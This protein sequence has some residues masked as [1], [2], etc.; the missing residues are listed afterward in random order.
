MHE[1]EIEVK[2]KAYRLSD[3]AR[4]LFQ[5]FIKDPLPENASYIVTSREGYTLLTQ[6]EWN[7]TNP[8]S[9]GFIMPSFTMLSYYPLMIPE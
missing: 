7:E 9:A 4:D 2:Y 3:S 6:E 8:M 5:T 1:L